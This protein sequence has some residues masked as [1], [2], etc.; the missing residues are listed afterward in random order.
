MKNIEKKWNRGDSGNPTPN[1]N[2]ENFYAEECNSIKDELMGFVTASG[3]TLSEPDSAQLLKSVNEA[4]NTRSLYTVSG[5][6]TLAALVLTSISGNTLQTAAQQ[7]R[8]GME[9][10]FV[11]TLAHTTGFTV[12]VDSL[13]VKAVVRKDGVAI[14]TGDIVPGEYYTLKYDGTN[15]R[16]MNRTVTNQNAI[17]ARINFASHRQ[18]WLDSIM[19]TPSAGFEIKAGNSI[20]LN[21]GEIYQVPVDISVT[22]ITSVGPLGLAIGTTGGV[23]KYFIPIVG[24]GSSGVTV[25]LSDK[26]NS[27]ASSAIPSELPVGYR[28]SWARLPFLCFTSNG[29]Q[30]VHAFYEEGW[31]YNPLRAPDSPA[32]SG[33]FSGSNQSF[34][35]VK[36][37]ALTNIL[38]AAYHLKLAC[39]VNT[40]MGLTDGFGYNDFTVSEQNSYNTE[41]VQPNTKLLSQ[42]T[43]NFLSVRNYSIPGGTFSIEAYG[44]KLQSEPIYNYYL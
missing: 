5:T 40:S 8:T 34:S 44:F 4:I 27:T 35:L 36:P 25:V 20:V 28:D 3:Q 10:G 38:W 39:P 33:G 9:V 17:P 11:A 13:A 21:N 22:N 30:L 14:A 42:S 37:T 41:L 6:S 16:L 29:T 26:V 7:Y 18:P 12:K 32:V 1:T 19:A 23:L 43:T 24:K 31:T 15:F 2:N